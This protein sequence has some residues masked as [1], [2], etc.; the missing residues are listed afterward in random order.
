[1]ETNQALYT[2]L[3]NTGLFRNAPDDALK[4]AA[5]HCCTEKVKRGR[6]LYRK[7]DFANCFYI[8]KKGYLMEQFSYRESL[9]IIVKVKCPG[10]YFGET[11]LMTDSDYRNSAIIME[12][13]EL[14]VMPKNTFLKL[15]WSSPSVCR[16]IVRE[17][18]ERL[19]NSA[20]NML[21]SMYLDAPGRLA[22]T[23]INLTTGS[24]GEIRNPE[25]RITQSALAS[26][27]GM[28]RQTAAKILGDWR[29]S[30]WLG[31]D[32]GKITVLDY[33]SL[34]NIILTSE[35]RC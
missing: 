23:L 14:I 25:V 28:A 20:Q 21:N 18:V 16:V 19:T 8:L 5:V 35:L 22:F 1:M 13:S 26:S 11:A 30:G 33:D 4:E 10:D 3:K 17:L 34:M 31:T 27:A 32:R 7:G 9:E 15:V 12:D 6:F 29:R 2:F 24:S